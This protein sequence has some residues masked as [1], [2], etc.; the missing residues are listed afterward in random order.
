MTALDPPTSTESPQPAK[1]KVFRDPVHDLI[2]FT[3]E[4]RWLLDLVDT[5]EFQ[6]LRRIH[7]L[8]LAHLVYPGAEHSRFV[9][10]LGVF[11]V[12][13]RMI[14]KLRH[15][16][17]GDKAIRDELDSKS[18]TIKAAAL[19]H[20]LGH[21]PFSH[22]FERVFRELPTPPPKHAEWSCRL[23]RDEKTEIGACL[24]KYEVPID[25][26]CSLIS[27]TEVPP[28]PLYLRDIVSSQLDADRMD[29]LLRDSLMTGSRYGQFDSEWILNALLIAEARIGELTGTKLCLDASKGT[30]GIEGFLF[31]R[32]QML[33]YVYGH[34][35]TR[36]YEAEL[37]QTLRLAFRLHPTLPDDTPTQV[38]TLLARTGN[39]TNKEYLS[40]DDEVMWWTL[41]RWATWEGVPAASDGALAR[42]LKDH[43]L[44]LVRR[45]QPWDFVEVDEG[46]PQLAAIQFYERMIKD[47][48]PLQY[49]CFVDSLE[50]LP[51]KDFRYLI[52]TGKV[53]GASKEASFFGEIFLVGRDDKAVRL[54]KHDKSPILTGLAQEFKLYRFYFNRRFTKEFAGHVKKFGVC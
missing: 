13:R 41:R 53:K 29:Y 24:R 52:E 3:P 17:V 20:D 28:D 9:H 45:L 31:A 44:R 40:L 47:D 19:L 12:A 7:Q 2:Y 37:V 14:R 35:T 42:V 18:K 43:S 15:R 38:R 34:K 16:H 46:E 32:L 36:A 10:S 54:S 8:G 48:N 30:G 25:E 23:L 6:R 4:D 50:D 51:Y 5:K 27:D 21:G 49:E 22:V 1:A 11:D 26:V 33:H 39:I